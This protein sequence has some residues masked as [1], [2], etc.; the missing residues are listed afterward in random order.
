MEQSKKLELQTQEIRKEMKFD[1]KKNITIILMT[2][3]HWILFYN[4]DYGINYLLFSI[5]IIGTL[6]FRNTALIKNALFYLLA[7]LTLITGIATFYYGFEIM[8]YANIVSVFILCSYAMAPKSSIPILFFQYV[9]TLFTTFY[10][11]FIDFVSIKNTEINLIKKTIKYALLSVIPVIIASIFL[12]IYTF[13]N[14]VLSNLLS[15]I[16]LTFISISGILYFL[17][18]FYIIYSYYRENHIKYLN[19]FEINYKNELIE[20]NENYISKF[21][22][23]KSELYIAFFVLILLNIIIGFQNGLDIY[24]IFFK[25]VLPD[26][27]SYSQYI[28]NGVNALIISIVL[29]IFIIMALFNSKISFYKNAK[30]VKS[31]AYLWIVQNIILAYI[32]FFKNQEYIIHF[33][34]THKRIGVYVFLILS[35]I[36]LLL[37]TYKVFKNKNNLFLFRKNS[38]SIYVIIMLYLCVD[39]SSIIAKSQLNR[40]ENPDF[41]YIL[42]QE[43]TALPYLYNYLKIDNENVIKLRQ[44][45]DSTTIE[46]KSVELEIKINTIQK[47]DDLAYEY[48]SKNWA[49]YCF[50]KNEIVDKK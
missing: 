17:Y 21:L 20:N 30:Y 45:K 50:K 44:E 12:G 33:G 41:N 14:P 16:D 34:Y 11:M 13:S 8:A 29:A 48:N 10:T 3:F 19:N 49:S 9:F 36:G 22:S 43:Y 32:C 25:K 31:V 37:T 6:I 38:L 1:S 7:T 28:H 23:L 2:L 27:L 40:T 24:F 26:N 18:S 5:L 47:M 35:I 46:R 4:Q 39:W 42:S 15:K